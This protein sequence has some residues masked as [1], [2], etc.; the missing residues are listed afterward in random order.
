[1]VETATWLEDIRDKKIILTGALQPAAFAENDAVFNIGC[2]VGA[3]QAIS[4]GVYIAMN[5]QIFRAD[6][7]VKNLVENKFES[8]PIY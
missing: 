1:M 7:V 4:A 3:I 6:E 5:G 8:I 2:A